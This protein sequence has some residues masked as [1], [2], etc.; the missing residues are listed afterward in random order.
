MIELGVIDLSA[1][2]R[3]R[4]AALLERWTWS[5][6]DSKLSPPRV[7]L[8][9]L[10]PEEIKFHGSLDLCVVGPELISADAA[11]IHTIRQQLP[12]KLVLC[13]VD[14][15]TYSFGL[16]EQLGRLGVDDVV[17]DSAT[18]EEFFR[19]LVLL[20]RRVNGRARGEVV[21]VSGARG[22][23]G[24]T[25]IAA[26]LGE[27]SLA[28]GRKTCLIDCDVRS[29]DLTRFLQVRPC[30]SEAVRLCV[31]Q[32]QVVTSELIA[33][34]A[35]QVWGDVEKLVCVPPPAGGD[36]AIFA[37]QRAARAFVGFI[38]GAQS[39]YET[40]VID[41]ARLPAAVLQSLYQI[42]DHGIL[43]LNRDPSGAFASRQSLALMTGCLRP[44]A[45]ISTVINDN[46]V[47]SMPLAL[48]RKEVLATPGKVACEV[49]IRRTPRAAPWP[50]SGYTPY[51]FLS[52]HFDR[53][54]GHGEE[55]GAVTMSIWRSA[56]DLG[57]RVRSS[58]MGG[59]SRKMK[60]RGVDDEGL[61][62]KP[63]TYPALEFAGGLEAS[64]DLVSKPMVV[65]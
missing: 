9:L 13:I 14:S 4:V 47:V 1:D 41:C 10:S 27:A 58:L 54:L 51:Q 60:E 7:S 49:I 18:S 5:S 16:V 31:D 63:V 25:F 46:S 26:S 6:P 12:G 50:C 39:L 62:V 55:G 28:K 40:I 64:E 42:A 24:T 48:L 38:E 35:C 8:S 11:Y 20:Q 2:G 36:E 33:E 43:V 53:L 56:G 15:T 52:R 17:L 32:Q 34:S 59:G 22:G 21:V 19:R 61:S 57:R 45:R 37:S 44:D 3:R 23:V 29:Q 30:V 65:A